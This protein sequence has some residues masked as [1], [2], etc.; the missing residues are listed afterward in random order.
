MAN[1]NFKVAGLVTAILL[2]S[3]IVV[4]LWTFSLFLIVYFIDLFFLKK[5]NNNCKIALKKIFFGSYLWSI[6]II[7]SLIFYSNNIIEN[8]YYDVK[9]FNIY[10][11]VWDHHRNIFS[12]NYN[13]ILKTLILSTLV[14]VYVYYFKQGENLIFSLFILINC[15]G[16]L[17]IYLF[18]KVIPNSFIPQIFINL[19]FSRVFV[20]HSV[21]GYPLIISIIFFIYK[22]L[23]FKINLNFIK[24]K[25]L[26]ISIFIILILVLSFN[27]NGF[28]NK[29]KNFYTNK[30]EKR[31]F[32][33]S[34]TLFNKKSMND[35]DFFWKKIREISSDGYY[36]TTF[37]SSGP[38]L[39]YGRKPHILN[40]SFIDS[41]AYFPYIATET[42]LILE[43]IYGISFEEPPTKFLG[44]IIDTCFRDIFEKRS[45][46]DWK[47]ISKKYNISGVIVPSDWNLQIEDK[48]ISQKFI[49]YILK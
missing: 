39:R 8:S 20:L 29:T 22:K 33:F 6:P 30:I 47:K 41:V 18:F 34:I 28:F 2:S 26:F 4:G 31:L 25:K 42:R 21:I 5:K 24:Y 15:F 7:I 10:M 9:D 36:V 35:D 37:N 14:V 44:A 13:Y 23:N 17:L 40:T 16:S 12:I 1:K 49:A 46:D 32:K 3:H 19:M 48:I 27:I 11:N 38:T 43:N 45:I